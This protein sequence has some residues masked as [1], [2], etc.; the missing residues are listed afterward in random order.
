LAK[1]VFQHP[2]QDFV[3]VLRN[4]KIAPTH[5]DRLLSSMEKLAKVP[6]WIDALNTMQKEWR[7]IER[8]RNPDAEIE[9]TSSR[10]WQMVSSPI[11]G[12]SG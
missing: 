5:R 12:R 10:N 6:P 4:R 3:T 7:E 2:T 8:G 9:K 11:I 1:V